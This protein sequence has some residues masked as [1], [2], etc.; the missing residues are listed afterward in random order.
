MSKVIVVV[1]GASGSNDHAVTESKP[2]TVQ[3]L[4]GHRTLYGVRDMQ[5]GQLHDV[6]PSLE[7]ALDHA[8]KCSG[9]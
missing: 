6:T 5:T 3:E 2:T 7:R 9:R 4:L 8:K 1:K